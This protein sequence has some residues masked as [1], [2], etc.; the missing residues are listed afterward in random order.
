MRRP[1]QYFGRALSN[2]FCIC[3]IARDLTEVINPRL[4]GRA[5]LQLVI[6]YQCKPDKKVIVVVH[7]RTAHLKRF[8][9]QT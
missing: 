6:K 7:Q 1:S 2:H 5:T 9:L 3:P 8:K 4:F